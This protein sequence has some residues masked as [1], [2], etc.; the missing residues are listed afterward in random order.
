MV[1]LPE[2]VRGRFLLREA[3]YLGDPA[4]I[5]PKFEDAIRSLVLPEDKVEEAKKVLQEALEAGQKGLPMPV[6][7]VLSEAE[8][9][10]YKAYFSSARGKLKLVEVGHL[11]FLALLQNYTLPPAIRKKV[12]L[13]SRAYMKKV[14]RPIPKAHGLARDLEYFDIYDRFISGA[15]AHLT[16]AKAAIAQGK[17]HSEEGPGA[18]KLKAGAFTLVN[19]GGF[20]SQVMENIQGIVEKVQSLLKAKSLGEVCYGE[21]QVTNTLM[22]AQVLAFYLIAKDELFIRANVK[23][24]VDTIK[25]VLHELGHRYENKFLHNNNGIFSLYRTLS[26]QEYEKQRAEKPEKPEPGETIV[27][28]GKTYKVTGTRWSGRGIQVQLERADDPKYKAHVPLEA[29]AELKGQ[30]SRDVSKPDYIGFVTNYAKKGGPAENFAEMFAFYCL[31][32]LPQKQV[33]PFEQLVFGRSKSAM[34][35]YDRRV[36]AEDKEFWQRR[37]QMHEREMQAIKARLRKYHGGVFDEYS[38]LGAAQAN[39]LRQEL[40]KHRVSYFAA[41]DGRAPTKQEIDEALRKLR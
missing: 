26:G 12:E 27:S 11:L 1:S 31:S 13:A 38:G 4:D 23:E 37:E 8:N 7:P 35:Q 32:K 2:R 10:A 14:R 9:V 22:K 17:S 34:Y 5:L 25:T 3:D 33:E 15:Y 6:G 29:W 41:R 39:K 18:T 36:G 20:D 30:K 21:V 24:N 40:E 28:K 16:V 19:A